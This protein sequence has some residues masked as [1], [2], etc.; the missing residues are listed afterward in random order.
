MHT[1]VSP[2]IYAQLY[3]YIYIDR[4]MALSRLAV[5]RARPFFPVCSRCVPKPKRM[6]CSRYVPGSVFKVCAG[7]VLAAMRGIFRHLMGW[8]TQAA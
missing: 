5:Y 6:L 2:R 1:M 3:I 7:V 8:G 4:Y